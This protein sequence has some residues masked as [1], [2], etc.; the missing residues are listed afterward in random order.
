MANSNYSAILTALVAVVQGTAGVGVVHNR[1]RLLLDWNSFLAAHTSAGKL[2]GWTVS[3]ESA[4][5]DPL[6]NREHDRSHHFVVRAWYA[7]D[8]ASASENLF[9]QLVDSVCDQL[10]AAAN[11]NLGGACEWTLPPNCRVIQYRSVGSVLCHYAE[12]VV[13]AHER[14]SKD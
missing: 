6:T 14:I 7:V 11:F 3:R 8:D 2:N 12:I 10:R 9:Q 4:P 5:E 13:V 1:Q